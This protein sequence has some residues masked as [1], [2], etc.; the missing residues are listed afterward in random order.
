MFNEKQKL[1]FLTTC[2]NSENTVR[3]F[4]SIFD[5]FEPYEK[6]WNVDL[7]VASIEQITPAMDDICGFRQTSRWVKSILIR[8]YV[9]WCV[10]MRFPGAH[11]VIPDIKSLG[12][13]KVRG[14]MISSPMHMQKWLDDV[15]EPEDLKTVGNVIR[16]ECWLAY[17]G[18]QEEDLLKVT[19][20]DVHFDT[21]EISLEGKTYPIYR[22]A[23]AC[24]KNCVELTSFAYIHP[25]YTTF[26]NAYKQR[27]PGDMLLRHTGRIYPSIY[28]L[29]EYI[30]TKSKEAYRAGKTK[31][32][33]S[34][35]RIY[36]SG[37]FY[38]KLELERAG[39]PVSFMEEAYAVSGDREYKL[40]SGRNTQEAKR[41]QMAN[42]YMQDY[43]RW[44]LAYSL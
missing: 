40:D 19:T 30:C 3:A 32:R 39:M 9:D 17:A 28:T 6:E 10:E 13:D 23:I 12:F 14:Q 38:R 7:S 29:R 37:C 25:N 4:R 43:R 33:L 21:M 31:I 11:N 35:F 1:M 34:Y 18:I 42:E 8:Q 27:L 20:S 24:L 15:L 36:L 5:A 22:E 44:K 41:R 26:E 16:A 2:V